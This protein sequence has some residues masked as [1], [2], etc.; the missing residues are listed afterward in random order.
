MINYVQAFILNMD[1]PRDFSVLRSFRLRSSMTD[2]ILNIHDTEEYIP[3]DDNPSSS[4]AIIGT[5]KIEGY[6]VPRNAVIGD[7]C[8][9]MCQRTATQTLAKHKK[10][11]YEMGEKNISYKCFMDLHHEAFLNLCS[12]HRSNVS[13]HYLPFEQGDEN[14]H[15]ELSSDIILV[16]RKN[17]DEIPVFYSRIPGTEH[18]GDLYNGLLYEYSE[19]GFN[20]LYDYLKKSG[21]KYEWYRLTDKQAGVILSNLF[22]L[23]ND[24]EN[25]SGKIYAVGR[26]CQP[27]ENY[28]EEFPQQY[29]SRIYTDF[30]YAIAF[31]ET[32][33]DLDE[34]K[35]FVS[36]SKR[37][38]FTYV[39][40]DAYKKLIKLIS[41]DNKLCDYYYNSE[42][43][44]M[45]LSNLNSENWI[46]T[47]NLYRRRF[48]LE[49]QFRAYY[50][51]RFL[52][53]LG[54][55]KKYYSECNCYHG[56]R[57]HTR[58]DNVIKFYNK[59]LPIEVKLNIK[60]EKDIKGQC[61]SYCNVQRM[62]LADD[63]SIDESLAW[64]VVLVIDREA[65]YIYNPYN[66]SMVKF[67]DL[68]NI[69][70]EPDIISLRNSLHETIT[71]LHNS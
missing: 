31:D 6:S 56:V 12:A 15:E 50:V 29:R 38:T 70:T 14:Y 2:N 40:G 47:T 46:L 53:I 59:Y 37:G 66:N 43:V 24:V 20:K 52:T 17:N 11:V 45:P 13:V 42:A 60:I 1:I 28:E 64:Q 61:N 68:D 25:Y 62:E 30:D 27:P 35:N 19:K 33:I 51:N 54:D 9:F 21:N 18:Y 32:P 44:P 67:F 34:F 8:F 63:F 22:W 49:D 4:Y 41:K 65:I 26:V 7:V 3:Y 39:L 23:S 55:T 36:F 48:C 5:G 69:K 57:Y 58:V 10:K 71:K 16:R